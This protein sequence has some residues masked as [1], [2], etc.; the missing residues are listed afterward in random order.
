LLSLIKI[1]GVSLKR[2][3]LAASNK[4]VWEI[5]VSVDLMIITEEDIEAVPLGNAGCSAVAAAPLAESAGG[6]AGLF[7]HLG[8][9]DVFGTQRHAARVGTN[10]RPEPPPTPG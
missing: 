9:G 7:K 1:T 4:V 3:F 5:R 6:I 2:H 10:D 8:D